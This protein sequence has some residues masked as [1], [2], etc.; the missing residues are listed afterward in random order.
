VTSASEILG[1]INSYSVRIKRR[2]P[3]IFIGLRSICVQKLKCGF[4]CGTVFCSMLTRT[5]N[6]R[7]IFVTFTSMEIKVSLTRLFRW[8]RADVHEVNQSEKPRTVKS[9]I[10]C[11]YAEIIPTAGSGVCVCKCALFA[12]VSGV[13]KSI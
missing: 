1:S 5:G 7:H 13:A 9:Y 11:K 2:F 4:V 3:W 12:H 6:W 10:F 8:G